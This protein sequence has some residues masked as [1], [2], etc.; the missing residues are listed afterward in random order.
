MEWGNRK[1]R[2]FMSKHNQTTNQGH[3][4][5]TKVYTTGSKDYTYCEHLDFL[6]KTN[7]SVR[8][9]NESL[10]IKNAWEGK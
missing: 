4:N 6:G 8:A 2:D 3:R 1:S 10:G 9:L 7:F 5:L